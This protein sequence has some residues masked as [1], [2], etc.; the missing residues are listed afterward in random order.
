MLFD[1]LP[2][3]FGSAALDR[4][5]AQV[6]EIEIVSKGILHAFGESLTSRGAD[7]RKADDQAGL[8]VISDGLVCQLSTKPLSGWNLGRSR[9]R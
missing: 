1:E 3:G 2:V 5:S 7:I 6:A 9:H 8:L 4:A